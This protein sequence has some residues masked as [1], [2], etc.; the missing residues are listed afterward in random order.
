M[1]SDD[2]P[3]NNRSEER[4]RPKGSLTLLGT[5]PA[6]L[7]DEPPRGLKGWI[8][9]FWRQFLRYLVTGTMVWVP[10][11][12]T[13]WV[14]W[15]VVSRLV[16]GIEGLIRGL[17]LF[18]NNLGGRVP[19]LRFLTHLAYMPGFGFLVIL[20]VFLFTGLVTRYLVARKIIRFGEGILER[21]PI[22]NRVYRA[23][24]QIRDVFVRRDGTVFQRVCMTEYPKEGSW[25]IGFVTST[26]RSVIQEAMGRDCV[27]LFVPT[28]PNP[29]SGFLLYVPPDSIVNID[30]SVEDAMK[31]IISGGAYLPE[32]KPFAKRPR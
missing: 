23:V 9:R 16:F 12:V 11:I 29:T 13:L 6:Y 22:V 28:T 27:A 20:A 30:I 10:L 4:A 24:T 7:G 5:M 17:V 19:F 3:K 26:E 31:V 14:V 18:L 25:V 15:L 8:R 21:I 1:N 32:Q 2:T